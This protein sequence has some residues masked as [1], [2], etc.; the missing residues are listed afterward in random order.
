MS[1]KTISASDLRSNLSDALEAVGSDDVLIVTRRG[2]K[3]RAI[4]DL[5]KLED[6]LAATDPAYLRTIKEARQSKEYFSHD[7]VFG[8]L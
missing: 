7:E 1:T 4:V 5:D 6:L 8:N 3:E 2:K